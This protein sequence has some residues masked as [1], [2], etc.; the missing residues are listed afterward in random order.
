MLATRPYSLLPMLQLQ[1][2]A[3]HHQRLHP[4]I[5]NRPKDLILL[6]LLR[7]LPPIHLLGTQLLCVKRGLARQET[8]ENLLSVKEFSFKVFNSRHRTNRRNGTEQARGTAAVASSGRRRKWE[9]VRNRDF[10]VKTIE[11][12]RGRR[13]NRESAL[14]QKLEKIF[15]KSLLESMDEKNLLTEPSSN[16][17]FW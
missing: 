13:S 14:T 1:P 4:R 17:Q 8:K 11:S 10:Q 5:Q 15:L 9:F 7:C 2:N 3:P 12:G 16:K 6:P